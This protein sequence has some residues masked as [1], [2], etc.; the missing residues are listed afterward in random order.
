M[1]V[2]GKVLIEA[3]VQVIALCETLFTAKN[4]LPKN[5]DRLFLKIFLAKKKTSKALIVWT[6]IAKIAIG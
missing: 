4:I 5:A 6:M 3:A 2:D 1:C